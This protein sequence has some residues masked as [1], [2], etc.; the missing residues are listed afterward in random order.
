MDRI[1]V[2]PGIYDLLLIKNDVYFYI[3][4]N[5]TL[6]YLLTKYSIISLLEKTLFLKLG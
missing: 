5:F 2:V 4:L 3:N 6:S 1:S